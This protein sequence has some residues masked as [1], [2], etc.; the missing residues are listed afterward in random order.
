VSEYLAGR[1]PLPCAHCNTEL[2]FAE[3]VDRADALGASAVAT[4]HYA[5][6][7]WVREEAGAAA[8]AGGNAGEARSGRWRLMRGRDPR[9]DQSY[10]LFGLTQAQLARAVFP[11]AAMTKDEVR[12]RARESGL[13]VADKDDSQE[14]CF[15]PGNDYAAVVEARAP[16]AA[17]PGE[18][19]DRQGQVIGGHT[20]VHRFTVGQRKGLR[21]SSSAPLYVLAIDASAARVTV[22]LRPDLERSTLEA[23][24][25]N[26]I[27][28]AAP[29]GARRA[30][31]QIRYRHP[32]AAAVV[33]PVGA[34]RVR[35]EFDAP[36]PAITPGQAVVLY[37]GDEVLGGG[38]IE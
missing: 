37:D 15:V 12:A 10:F 25:V 5:R 1:T 27:G 11:L 30:E 8:T 29:L 13:P 7:E 32:P 35:V 23:S 20:G 36:Q 18:I 22:G 4:G 9:K 16:G 38:W 24:G 33:H 17:R 14:I 21:L 28:G 19:V 2:K 3:L 26:W 6:V 34:G 31:A